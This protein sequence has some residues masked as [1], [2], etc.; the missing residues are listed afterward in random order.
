MTDRIDF[1]LVFEDSPTGKKK[2]F[3][4]LL[5]CN[6]STKVEIGKDTLYG[7]EVRMRTDRYS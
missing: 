6:W 5:K 7:H 3:L 1:I 4:Q 2:E